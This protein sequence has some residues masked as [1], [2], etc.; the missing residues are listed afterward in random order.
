MDSPSSHPPD[1]HTSASTDCIATPLQQHT[2]G[3]LATPLELQ[4]T[5]AQGASTTLLLATSPQLEGVSGR[6][7]NANQEATPVDHRP[8]D[9]TELANSVADHA[10]DADAADRL[11][12]RASQATP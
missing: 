8:S 6:H 12:N 10:L 9:V 5:P 1:T 2:G 3:K 4:K 7:F 11:R